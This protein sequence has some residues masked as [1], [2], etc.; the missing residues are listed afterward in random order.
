MKGLQE[1]GH[2]CRIASHAEY[3]SFVESHGIE[4]RPVGGNPADLI[5]KNSY[6]YEPIWIQ[7]IPLLIFFFFK[8]KATLCK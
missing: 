8:K 2:K 6:Y 5:V 3:Q 7:I 4:F 1:A